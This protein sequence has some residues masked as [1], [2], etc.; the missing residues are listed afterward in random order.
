MC[1]EDF[2]PT[3]DSIDD[4]QHSLCNETGSTAQKETK[5]RQRETRQECRG[6]NLPPVSTAAP[7]SASNSG[8]T[9]VTHTSSTTSS[10]SEEYYYRFSSSGSA[11]T[12]DLNRCNQSKTNVNS[13]K[14]NVA[15]VSSN[16]GTGTN[17][18]GQF[19]SPSVTSSSVFSSVH[20]ASSSLPSTSSEATS[21]QI[22]AK[23]M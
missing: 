3:Y 8:H 2:E 9:I 18:I 22:R 17:G 12:D 15:A 10:A 21:N 7:V 4:Y 5:T 13:A 20:T 23:Y 16:T 1:G 11:I 19:L 14:A 6:D